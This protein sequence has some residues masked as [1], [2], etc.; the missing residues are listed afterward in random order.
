MLFLGRL[1]EWC[2][3]RKGNMIMSTDLNT[4]LLS[5]L[6]GYLHGLVLDQESQHHGC[7]VKTSIT[8]TKGEMCL[9]G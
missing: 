7:Q 3:S 5:L 4:C 1:S 8:Q 2:W 6:Q 9:V